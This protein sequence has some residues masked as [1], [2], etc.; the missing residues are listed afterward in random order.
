MRRTVS[1]IAGMLLRDDGQ[2][3]VEYALIILLVAVALVAT[4]G[5]LGVSL[6]GLYQRAIDIFS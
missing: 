2:G 6:E 5:A 4:L 1:R 3:L